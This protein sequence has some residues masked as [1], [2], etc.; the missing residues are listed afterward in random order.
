LLTN[1]VRNRAINTSDAR[2][3]KTR[4]RRPSRRLF[5]LRG[6]MTTG[7]DGRPDHPSRL[8]GETMMRMT[9]AALVACCLSVMTLF[10]GCAGSTPQENAKWYLSDKP[11]DMRVPVSGTTDPAQGAPDDP[12]LDE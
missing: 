11:A 12:S 2:K 1:A 8:H 6:R 5:S 3:M 4:E 9:V 7:I 10:S